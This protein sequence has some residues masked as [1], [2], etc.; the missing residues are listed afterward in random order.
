MLRLA[1]MQL[2]G[3]GCVHARDY[4]LLV[5]DIPFI[6]QIVRLETFLL[7]DFWECV[8]SP[9]AFDQNSALHILEA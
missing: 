3:N 7:K 2:G 1:A 8:G 9:I 4:G 5:R 6:G